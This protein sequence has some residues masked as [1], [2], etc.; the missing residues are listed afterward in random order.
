MVDMS[1]I[2]NKE[3]ENFQK[4]LEIRNKKLKGIVR[5]KPDDKIDELIK[6]LKEKTIIL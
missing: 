4:E 6:E 3:F 2:I 1:D 5:F